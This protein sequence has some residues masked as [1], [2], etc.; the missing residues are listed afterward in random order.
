MAQR[1]KVVPCVVVAVAVDV[2]DVLRCYDEAA[3]FAVLAQRIVAQLLRTCAI[4]P[5]ALVILLLAR[6]PVVRRSLVPLAVEP[7]A[8]RVSAW[9]L[10]CVRHK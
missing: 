10:G 3:F 5:G 8:T 1:A 9:A 7:A 2:I 6:A 4:T